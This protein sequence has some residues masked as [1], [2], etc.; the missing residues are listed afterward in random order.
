MIPMSKANRIFSALAGAAIILSLSVPRPAL[1]AAAASPFA[2][3]AIT[4]ATLPGDDGPALAAETAL[5]E[6]FTF[7][8]ERDH[9]FAIESQ[10]A[11]ILRIS[12]DSSSQ[13]TYLYLYTPSNTVAS[14]IDKADAA[15][16]KWNVNPWGTVTLTRA[17]DR[18]RSVLEYKVTKG[19]YTLKLTGAQDSQC[20][21]KAEI[22]TEEP[23]EYTDKAYAK[24][25]NGFE[26]PCYLRHNHFGHEHYAWH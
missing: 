23:R 15:E 3:P 16:G 26:D 20:S 4:V 19:T 12:I 24:R 5:E 14:N 11:G 21:V 6:S 17:G 1:G 9:S 7:S 2:G 25:F 22:L 8:R 18:A 10:G 13:K